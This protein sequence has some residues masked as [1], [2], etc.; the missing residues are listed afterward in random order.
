MG[1]SLWIAWALIGIIGGFMV[2]KLIS[3]I[4]NLTLALCVS[5]CGAFCL[6]DSCFLYWLAPAAQYRSTVAIGVGTGDYCAL[7]WWVLTIASPK[8]NYDRRY[9]RRVRRPRH[10]RGIQQAPLSICR[11]GCG[12]LMRFECQL[13]LLHYATLSFDTGFLACKTT[14]IS[15]VWHDVPCR[16]C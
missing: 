3:G 5:I 6:V 11:Y 4:R 9:H 10:M 2:G 7:F 1:A 8:R 12:A 15:K 14:E 16:T 13:R